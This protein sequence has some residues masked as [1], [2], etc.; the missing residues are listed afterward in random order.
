M[1]KDM[2]SSE[3]LKSLYKIDV[4][5]GRGLLHT[6][7]ARD[8]EGLLSID[9]YDI[10]QLA[11]DYETPL[12]IICAQKLVDNFRRFREA[13]STR[14]DLTDIA[15]SYKTNY[16]PRVCSTLHRE[17]ALAEVTSLLEL[18][19]AERLGVDPD[20][21]IFNGPAKTCE[22][23]LKAMK[24]GIRVIFVDSVSELQRIVELT[25]KHKLEANVGIRL[26][27]PEE[28]LNAWTKF[29]LNMQSEAVKAC[30]IIS[31]EPRLNFLGLHSHLGTQITEIE[32]YERILDFMLKFAGQLKREAGL[33]VQLIDVGGGFPDAGLRPI[34]DD[35]SVWSPPPID[36]YAEA[37]CNKILN[38]QD[39]VRLVLEPGRALVNDASFLIVRVLAVK[40]YAQDGRW[41]I[42][43]G[44]VNL[45]PSA[46]HYYHNIIPYA[47]RKG[48]P[49][50]VNV[51]G[52]LCMQTDYIG[53]R[54]SL[55]PLKEG[56]LLFVCNTGA[57]TISCSQVF[58]K[59]RAGAIIV[60]HDKIEW[61]LRP[62][63]VEHAL[64]LNLF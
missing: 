60:D 62:E 44:G 52:P 23:L 22:E 7:I 54:R 41:V 33:G 11:R 43:D 42:V 28:D 61:A 21:I 26:R 58:M 38:F 4:Y 25:A 16:L 12:F 8:D 32:R 56:D 49:W 20:S 10:S 57:Y 37:I 50:K 31:K 36:D 45:M 48:R 35:K 19:I 13:F 24:M 3:C 14:Y 9:G 47:I 15:Y 39:N 46:T 1:I 59:T 63:T 18:T 17:G 6:C 53:L 55:P 2:P 27:A 34:C 40:D 29:G 30:K 5:D 64:A 51:G